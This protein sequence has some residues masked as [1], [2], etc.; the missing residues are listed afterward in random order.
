M[1]SWATNLTTWSSKCSKWWIRSESIWS[2]ILPWL[3]ASSNGFANYF[4]VSSN[5]K[6]SLIGQVPLRNSFI[7]KKHLRTNE[8]SWLQQASEDLILHGEIRCM[9]WLNEVK[10]RKNQWSLIG[11]RWKPNWRRRASLSSKFTQL[12]SP[13][14]TFGANLGKVI[15]QRTL[16]SIANL[17][18]LYVLVIAKI[19][20]LSSLPQGLFA[21][22]GVVLLWRSCPA[23]IF[24]HCFWRWKTLLLWNHWPFIGAKSCH[25]CHRICKT[26]KL[27]VIG[28]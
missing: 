23:P 8:S 4:M 27:P 24:I 11:R 9:K 22:T 5:L 15:I 21:L 13:T 6:S 25:L 16:M 2:E 14:S 10:Q 1:T 28:D 19:L 17:T 3:S 26:S 20:E 12:L 18:L 7:T